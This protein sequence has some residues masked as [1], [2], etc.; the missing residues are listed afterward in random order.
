MKQL[1]CLLI[2]IVCLFAV[3]CSGGRALQMEKTNAEVLPE[4]DYDIILYETEGPKGEWNVF[5]IL[6]VEGDEYEFVPPEL[7]KQIR[8]QEHVKADEALDHAA[9]L[10]GTE[11]E[12]PYSVRRIMIEDIPIGYEL[13]PQD[14]YPTASP[15]GNLLRI[16]YRV[17]PE[18]KVHFKVKPLPLA[19]PYGR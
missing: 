10:V 7:G 19:E 11:P 5:V 15:V 6:D 2:G 17:D 3:A 13:I 8:R 12:R 1:W 16:E 4:G 9:L 18:G 14:S